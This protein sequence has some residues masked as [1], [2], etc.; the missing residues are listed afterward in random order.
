M[1]THQTYAEE[2]RIIGVSY[3]VGIKFLNFI[4]GIIDIVVFVR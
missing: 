1:H 3:E 4:A 2:G